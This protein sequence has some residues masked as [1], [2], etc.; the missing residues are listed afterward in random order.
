MMSWTI[1]G[2]ALVLFLGGF[3]L[4]F[5]GAGER[6]VDHRAVGHDRRVAARARD[7][8]LA[9]GHRLGRQLF[10]LEMPFNG[11]Q[12]GHIDLHVIGQQTDDRRRRASIGNVGQIDVGQASTTR[13]R[14]IA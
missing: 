13:R 1:F 9:S 8:R 11:A 7:A 14:F 12:D 6:L 10:R 2:L 4:Q 5:L 3:G